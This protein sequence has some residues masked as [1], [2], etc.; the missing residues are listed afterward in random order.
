MRVYATTSH[1][2][3]LKRDRTPTHLPD[4]ADGLPVALAHA[5]FI[6]LL[7]APVDAQD[8]AARAHQRVDQRHRVLQRGEQADLAGDGHVQI[9][10][11]RRHDA[12]QQLRLLQQKGAVVALLGD[13]LR[14]AQV[15]VHR[16]DARDAGQLLGRR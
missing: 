1:V 15:Q 6:H 11:Q 7:G 9:P 12:H 4:R 5:V 8:R 13:A 3:K 16:A 14:A 10:R 2:F